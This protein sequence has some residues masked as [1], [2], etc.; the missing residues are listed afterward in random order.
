MENE[1]KIKFNWIAF[2]FNGAAYYA[3]YGNIKKGLI[4]AVIGFL[5]LTVFFV[6]LYGGFKANSELPVKQ[7]PFD[8]ARAIMVSMFHVVILICSVTI[9]GSHTGYLE[10]KKQPLQIQS[11]LSLLSDSGVLYDISAVWQVEDGDKQFVAFYAI[12]GKTVLQI[13]DGIHEMRIDNVDE[14]NKFVNIS[15][16]ELHWKISKISSNDD[17]YYLKIDDGE[18]TY[19]LDYVSELSGEVNSGE[20]TSEAVNDSDQLEYHPVSLE[21]LKLDIDDSEGK[22]VRVNSRAQFSF[23]SLS[24][25]K[26][27]I[28]TNSI[29]VDIDGLDREVRKKILQKC[30]SS[31]YS[32]FCIVTVSG[33]VQ[34]D[35]F[36]VMGIIAEKVEFAND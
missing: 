3:G 22:R 33:V 5:P 6:N 17:T 21:D 26:S 32:P 16:G 8:W 29:S 34:E 15:S 12:G 13:N 9:I 31:T 27:I 23:G 25:T 7:Q 20:S 18:F 14:K 4:M 2:L 24:L 28:D 19:V 1:Q 10:N 30:E 11:E 35:E 36:G